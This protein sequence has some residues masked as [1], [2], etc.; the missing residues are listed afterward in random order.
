MANPGHAPER[1]PRSGSAP[2]SCSSL[3]PWLPPGCRPD[4]P[5]ASTRSKRS[6]PSKVM[7]LQTPASNGQH[8]ILLGP[9]SLADSPW[10]GLIAYWR[11]TNE[12]DRT[13]TAPVH[14][15]KAVRYCEYGRPDVLEDV[16][17]PVPKD[18]QVLIKVRAA[19]LNSLDA[20]H[21]PRPV[22]CSPGGRLAQTKDTRL[23]RTSPARWKRSAKTSR[24]SNR[25]TKCSA[26]VAALWPS[27]LYFRTRIGPQA[28]ERHL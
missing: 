21:G 20:C 19:S 3:S 17:K 1:A 26:S 5:P 12:C 10:W 16:E 28:G 27:M 13:T 7:K 6:A 4:A 9:C 22:A 11:S 18:N 25:A 24:N 23:G 8:A 15:M 14:P 2:R